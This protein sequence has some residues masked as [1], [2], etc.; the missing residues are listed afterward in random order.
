LIGAGAC[1]ASPASPREPRIPSRPLPDSGPAIALALVS[2]ALTGVLFLLIL[3]LVAGWNVAPLA[4]AAAVTGLPVGALIGSRATRGG[5]VSRSAAGCL[6][7]GAGVLAL[8]W[9]PGANPLWTLPPQLLAG[10]GM[11]LSLPALGGE[12]LPERTARDAAVLL[13]I[14]H[15]ARPP[16]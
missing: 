1:V 2:A 9:L 15:A 14:R 6:L 3:L 13:T 5:A 8:A 11:G 12:L 10:L 16:A 4:A 7:V